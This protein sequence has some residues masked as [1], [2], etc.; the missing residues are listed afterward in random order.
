MLALERDLLVD[1]ERE[2]AE[3]L[4]VLGSRGSGTTPFALEGMAMAALRNGRSER[5]LRLVGATETLR[6]KSGLAG[7]PW[8][9][10]RLAAAVAAGSARLP[11]GRAE[12]LRHEGRRMTA[13]QAVGYALRD[14]LDP[15][16]AR[17]TP[18]VPLTRREQ[19]VAALVTQGLTNR[20]IGE[21]L[22]V[23]ERTV[24]AHLDR[25][26]TKLGVRSRAQVAAWAAGTAAG[27]AG[28][29]RPATV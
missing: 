7:D 22:R 4:R 8:W 19:E 11:D 14:K 20:Q 6:R 26:R 9:R 15:A 10:E 16:A 25:L 23:S 27:D 13:A 17:A 1:A 24:E 29:P 5:G 21:R 12:A 18:P 3:V 28:G 2:F